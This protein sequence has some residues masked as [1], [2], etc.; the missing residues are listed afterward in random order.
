MLKNKKGGGGWKGAGTGVPRPGVVNALLGPRGKKI[1]S[2][3]RKMQKGRLY[4]CDKCK[5]VDPLTLAQEKE[6]S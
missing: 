1:M 4:G 5:G 3:M 2:A 6:I